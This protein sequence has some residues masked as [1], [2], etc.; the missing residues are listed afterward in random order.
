[1]ISSNNIEEKVFIC[2]LTL[3][4]FV[5]K[6]LF[7]FQHK[8]FPIIISFIMTINKSQGESL[9]DVGIYLPILDFF[10]HG[11]LSMAISRLQ[12]MNNGIFLC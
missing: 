9:K 8:Q 2:R 11:Q 6:I 1:M 4:P 7:Q 5:S 10:S 3:I 12:H